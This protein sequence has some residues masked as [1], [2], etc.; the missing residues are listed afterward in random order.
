M[1]R[2][3][4]FV[5]FALEKV[6]LALKL[7]VARE[8]SGFERSFRH[9]GFH[10]AA[11]FG[12]VPAVL[13]PAGSGEARNVVESLL[14]LH[15]LVTIPEL[16]FAESRRVDKMRATGHTDQL[17]VRGRM[18]AAIVA[19]P[20]RRDAQHLSAQQVVDDRGFARTR[21]TQQDAGFSGSEILRQRFEAETEPDADRVHG[22]ARRGRRNFG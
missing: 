21:G 22:H 4:E 2:L 19:F 13:E 17:T 6:Q 9:R 1:L 15:V 18:A 10:G 16:D 14:E 7:L 12:L 5:L 8:A 11:R 20:Y 3:C